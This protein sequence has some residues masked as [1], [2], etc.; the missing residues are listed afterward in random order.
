MLRDIVSLEPSVQH[1][2]QIVGRMRRSRRGRSL[3][4]DIG[5]DPSVG[6][7]ERLCKSCA[8]FQSCELFFVHKTGFW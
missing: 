2:D 8:H 3:R 1:S 4:I 7:V 5:V 6:S